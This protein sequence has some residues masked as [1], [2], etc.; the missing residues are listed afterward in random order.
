MIVTSI[1]KYPS[2]SA[3]SEHPW[4]L[5]GYMTSQNRFYMCQLLHS[6]VQSETQLRQEDGCACD[7][8]ASRI[9]SKGE[10]E[11]LLVLIPSCSWKSRLASEEKGLWPLPVSF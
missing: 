6:Q 3:L 5:T 2:I 9:C 10:R 8:T 7:S 11:S 1:S 4:M